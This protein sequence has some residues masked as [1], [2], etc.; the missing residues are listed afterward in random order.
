MINKSIKYS[1]KLK[2]LG[3]L[4]K[5][6]FTQVCNCKAASWVWVFFSLAFPG[7]FRSAL[8]CMQGARLPRPGA[9]A[10]SKT[11]DFQTLLRKKQRNKQNLE[12]EMTSLVEDNQMMLNVKGK[13][14]PQILVSY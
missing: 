3:F 7:I 4:G 13:K 11:Y 12:V 1:P 5:S 6:G 2:A 10:R 14:K 8:L 9:A